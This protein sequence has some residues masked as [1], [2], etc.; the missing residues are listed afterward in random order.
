MEIVIISHSHFPSVDI[1]R[2]GQMDTLVI[3]RIDGRYNDSVLL[4]GSVDDAKVLQ[5]KITEAVKS[6]PSVIGHKFTV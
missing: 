1:K 6:R 3:Y 4:P 2:A 5:A